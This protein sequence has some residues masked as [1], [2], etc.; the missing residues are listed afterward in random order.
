VQQNTNSSD[1]GGAAGP[2]TQEQLDPYQDALA[3]QDTDRLNQN[4]NGGGSYVDQPQF[5]IKKGK[6]LESQQEFVG[7]KRANITRWGAI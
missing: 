7:F 1:T 2:E 6:V 4:G 3:N 5:I